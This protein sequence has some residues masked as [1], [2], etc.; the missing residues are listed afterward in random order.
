MSTNNRIPEHAENIFEQNDPLYEK[1]GLSTTPVELGGKKPLVAGWTKHSGLGA[2]QRARLRNK[3]PNASI[4]LLAG[5]TLPNGNLVGFLDGDHS[6]FNEFLCRA[7]NAVS[8][9]IGQKGITVFC[10][11]DPGTK[12]KKT[13]QKGASAPILEIMASSGMTVLPPSPHPSGSEYRWHG[14]PLYDVAPNELPLV[15]SEQLTF[16]C[17]VCRHSAALAIVDGG[18]DV[19]AHDL[20][21]A[22]TASG[23][24]MLDLEL[25]WVA[26][27]L[28]GL[29]PKGYRGNTAEETLGMLQS[30]REKKLGSRN[31]WSNE[32]DPGSLGPIP[33]G[34]LSDGRF[35]F[36]EQPR[37]LLIV[38]TSTRLMTL[39][40]LVNLA[41]IEF[42]SDNFPTE[43]GN[44]RDW[45]WLSLDGSGT[46]KGWL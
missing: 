34:Y 11:F 5:T 18:P 41:P 42:W 7:T 30:A 6:G 2:E 20:M 31:R 28:N 3:Y 26:Y 13:R 25:P 44:Q 39:G 29:L 38:E 19:K 23:I 10:Q 46:A 4:G 33:L 27:C 45:R 21:L 15:G 9:K 17:E 14:K 16:I 24:A 12:S 43:K 22:L 35:V 40:T 36:F 37:R 1:I 32:Y 8:G